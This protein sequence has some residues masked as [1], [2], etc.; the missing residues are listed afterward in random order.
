VLEGGATVDAR[1]RNAINLALVTGAPI[2]VDEAVL[3]QA[4]DSE[5]EVAEE[6]ARAIAQEREDS[7]RR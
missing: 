7:P 3:A 4:A 1:P 2:L 5:R 6:L